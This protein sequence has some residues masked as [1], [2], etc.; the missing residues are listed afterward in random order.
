VVDGADRLRAGQAVIATVAHPF[1]PPLP[2]PAIQ[3]TPAPTRPQP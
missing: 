2:A 3:T 1:A